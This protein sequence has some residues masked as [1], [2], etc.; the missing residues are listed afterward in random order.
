MLEKNTIIH[1]MDSCNKIL[2]DREDAKIIHFILER[3][4]EKQANRCYKAFL[5]EIARQCRN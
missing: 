1:F 5:N 3:S 2:F 4:S